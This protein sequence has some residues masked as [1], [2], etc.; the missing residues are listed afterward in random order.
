MQ[1]MNNIKI[2]SN[3]NKVVYLLKL[4]D[5]SRCFFEELGKIIQALAGIVVPAFN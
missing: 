5:S 3:I 2:R 4:T 1:G